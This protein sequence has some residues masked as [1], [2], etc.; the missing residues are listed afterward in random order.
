MDWDHVC[1][2]KVLALR[3]LRYV[4]KEMMLGR[5]YV[6]IVCITTYLLIPNLN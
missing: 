3:L 5:V 2:A 1:I 4:E 6:A